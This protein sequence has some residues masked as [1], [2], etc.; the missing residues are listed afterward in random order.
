MAA[1]RPRILF[2]DAYDSFTNNIIAL[3]RY[4]L[5][6]RVTLIKIDDPRFLHTGD[7]VF[8]SF[9][10]RFD[11]VVVGPGPGNPHYPADTGIIDK[12]W[13]LADQSIL[14]VL[15]ICLGFQSLVLA[16]GGK[17]VRLKEPRHGLI[18]FVEHRGKSLFNGVGLV[19][20][21][22]Y[23]SLHAQLGHDLS[24]LESLWMPSSQTPD[25]EPLGWDL[26]DEANGPV[27]M[28]VRHLVKPYW[29]VQYHPE[30]ICTNAAGAKVVEHWWGEAHAWKNR[31]IKTDRPAGTDIR[32]GLDS[33]YGT[34]DDSSPATPDEEVANDEILGTQPAIRLIGHEESDIQ[35]DPEA[36]SCE[37]FVNW[38]SLHWSGDVDVIPSLCKLVREQTG[39]HPLLLE[40][41]TKQGIPVRAETGRFSI[42]ALVDDDAESFRYWTAGRRLEHVCHGTIE[43]NV[44]GIDG[45]FGMLK[46]WTA[47]RR[48]V[49]G[50]A[51]VPFWGGLI[52]YISYEAG[53]ETIDVEPLPSEGDH[54]D[55]CFVAVRRS[56]VIDHV[57]RRIFVLD[58]ADDDEWVAGMVHWVKSMLCTLNIKEHVDSP[59]REKAWI[60]STRRPEE[61]EYCDKVGVCQEH[62]RA[63]DSYELCLTD[64]STLSFVEDGGHFV[65]NRWELYSR[66]R[67]TN[68]APFGALLDFEDVSIL[69]SSPERF[70]SWSREGIC[71]FRPIKGTV[72][73]GGGM[74]REKAEDILKSEK[75]QAENL[76]IVDLIRHDLNDVVGSRGG[77]AEV[78]QLMQVEEY[79]TVYQLVSVIRGQLDPLGLSALPGSST[80]SPGDKVIS[81]GVDVLHA[82]L[83]PD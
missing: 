23:H 83:P 24:N 41:G 25:L 80:G 13:R 47:A 28:A 21:T 45:A 48:F 44:C 57:K 63:G 42:V 68:P 67:S 1:Q 31:C 29:G 43:S 30:S 50:P 9:L 35:L 6:A 58:L 12:L 72:Q 34:D 53:L 49:G 71:E 77:M 15:G 78:P 52:G 69:S 64:Q 16:F 55:L 32:I 10:R 70:L 76:M 36:L 19:K 3:L 14:P 81:T 59:V 22:Q 79:A 56:L 75:E 20:A 66:L 46:S 8:H 82:S 62:I 74:T 2:L 54:A 5:Q 39:R 4:S 61:K 51:E 27:L 26:S 17:V 18:R 33:G 73:K 7:N 65:P 11:G 38:K 37:R 60:S 40:S